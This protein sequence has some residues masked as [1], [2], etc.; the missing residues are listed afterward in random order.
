M[1][2]GMAQY[3]AI[4]RRGSQW[5]S[6][7][8]RHPLV[9]GVRV[10]SSKSKVR[11]AGVNTPFQTPLRFL[12]SPFMER[13]NVSKRLLSSNRRGELWFMANRKLSDAQVRSLLGICLRVGNKLPAPGQ[14]LKTTPNLVLNPPPDYNVCRPG[15]PRLN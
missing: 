15:R 10:Q 8:F 1:P 14:K 3:R 6:E 11:P 12:C 2:D 9:I 13:I 4:A 5:L 7:T